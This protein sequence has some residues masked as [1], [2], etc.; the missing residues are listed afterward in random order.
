MP[1]VRYTT[2][3]ITRQY[4]PNCGPESQH[5]HNVC[6][7]GHRYEGHRAR[8]LDMP[9]VARVNPEKHVSRPVRRRK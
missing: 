2:A 5:V 7:C 9:R 3:H 8:E 1:V 6:G 4:C